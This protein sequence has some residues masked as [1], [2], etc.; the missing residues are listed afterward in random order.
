MIIAT[1]ALVFAQTAQV[2]LPPRNALVERVADGVKYLETKSPWYGV[3]YTE[4]IEPKLTDIDRQTVLKLL[5]P[6]EELPGYV[7]YM[8]LAHEQYPELFPGVH[9]GVLIGNRTTNLSQNFRSNE[10]RIVAASTTS[11]E[12]RMVPIRELGFSMRIYADSQTAIEQSDT[13]RI[14]GSVKIEP[15]NPLPSGNVIGAIHWFKQEAERISLDFVLG[16]CE[17]R[18][19]LRGSDGIDLKFVEAI[20]RMLEK[21]IRSVPILAPG[22]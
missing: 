9:T 2:A 10:I 20:A 13:R 3:R 8:G 16:R 15:G 5:V 11:G 22:E 12:G 6:V 14:G 21:R 18:V 17:V 19:E 1:L 7:P 4:I